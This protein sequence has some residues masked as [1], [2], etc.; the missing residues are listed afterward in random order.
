MHSSLVTHIRNFVDLN[1]HE[2]AILKEYAK[3]QSLK[4]KEDLLSN[5]D[6]C[7]SIHFVVEG[8]LRMFFISSKG[9]EQITQ[10][11]IENW[12]L[13]DYSSYISNQPS[14]YFIQAIEPSKVISI[15]I[16]AYDHLLKEIPQLEQYF[17]LIMQKNLAASQLRIKYLY[18]LSKEEFYNHFA[19]SFPVFIFKNNSLKSTV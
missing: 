8:C 6:V 1:E 10:F 4:K 18:E 3:P 12:W 16:N 2:V 19:N 11:A 13:T 5:G 14:D 15:D 17:R 9:T 7:R